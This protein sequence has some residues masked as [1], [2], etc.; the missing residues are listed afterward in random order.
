[1]QNQKGFTLIELMIVIAIIGILAALALP[2]YQNYVAKS[3]VTEAFSLADGQKPY[4][5]A[6]NAETGNCPTNG[7]A[8]IAAAASITGDYVDMV[9]V[10]G[11]GDNCTV[12]AQFKAASPDTNINDNIAGETVTF[13][14]N[15]NDTEGGAIDWICESTLQQRYLPN[16][17]EG[18]SVP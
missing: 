4:V 9:T 3:Q 7:K 6:A 17:C 8:G 5:V 12:Q 11:E 15:L 1:M 10:G 2:A 13:S 18:V 14:A 16:S